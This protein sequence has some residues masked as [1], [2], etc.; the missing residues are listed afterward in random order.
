Q[1]SEKTHERQLERGGGKSRKRLADGSERGAEPDREA[2]GDR[3][4]RAPFAIEPEQT[5]HLHENQRRD[6]CRDHARKHREHEH[7]GGGQ[8]RPPHP[9][10]EHLE[11]PIHPRSRHPE[12]D[13]RGH[14]GDGYR[15]RFLERPEQQMAVEAGSERRRG[16]SKDKDVEFDVLLDEMNG[17][18]TD[19]QQE[20][21]GNRSYL[22]HGS[23]LGAFGARPMKTGSIAGAARAREKAA[24]RTRLGPPR[25]L[26]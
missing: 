5:D 22:V 19:Q 18:G 3:K 9:A 23:I 26:F 7:G 21:N 4:S 6:D 17:E 1:Q 16:D 25:P 2:G 11:E 13:S 20:E 10:A 24:R 15:D 14:Y 8:K 12:R